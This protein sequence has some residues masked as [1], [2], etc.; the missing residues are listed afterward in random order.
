MSTVNIGGKTFLT[1]NI[2]RKINK[3]SL[4]LSGIW[5]KKK[6]FS[7][8]FFWGGKCSLP[9]PTPMMISIAI[10]SSIAILLL[11][12]YR[13]RNFRYRPALLLS[14]AVCQCGECA[15]CTAAV[16]HSHCDKWR[17]RDRMFVIRDGKEPSS[18][19]F[20]SVL[21]LR[22]PRFGSARSGQF[23]NWQKWW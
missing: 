19:G 5:P 11:D 10:V 20:G 18:F 15:V 2:R 3:N 23:C 13:G 22:L 17:L 12:T 8:F 1:E 14:A 4:I 6:T 21:V 16:T 9:P 7:R